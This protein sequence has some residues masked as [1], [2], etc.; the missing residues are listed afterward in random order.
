[1]KKLIIFL[2]LFLIIL[3]SSIVYGEDDEIRNSESTP[4]NSYTLNVNDMSFK[5]SN[6]IVTNDFDSINIYVSLRNFIEQ[7]GGSINWNNESKTIDILFNGK[8]YLLEPTNK[9]VNVKTKSCFM[10]IDFVNI[11]DNNGV[12][13][14]GQ[15]GEVIPIYTMDN[16]SYLSYVD[17]CKLAESTGCDCSFNKGEKTLTIKKY[18]YDIE[19]IVS[20]LKKDMTY[21]YVIGILGKADYFESLVVGG[22]KI[23]YKANNGYVEL[24]FSKYNEDNDMMLI[25]ISKKYNNGEKIE[26]II[27]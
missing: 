1:M 26:N 20:K 3:S 16:T 27:L 15:Y 12:Y 7:F 13:F 11:V 8:E 21:S 9:K 17:F 18:N 23:N 14:M 2:S 5:N 4:V 25:S 6:I 10:D 19:Y 22:C 24:I